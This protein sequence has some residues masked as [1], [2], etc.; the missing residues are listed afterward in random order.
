MVNVSWG[1]VTAGDGRIATAQIEK[2]IRM[3]KSLSNF[4]RASVRVQIIH[5]Q[6]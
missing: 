6:K 5:D 1:E 2:P 3:D 4:S